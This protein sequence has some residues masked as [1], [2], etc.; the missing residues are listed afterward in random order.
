MISIVRLNGEPI[1][2]DLALSDLTTIDALE[3]HVAQVVFLK[4]YQCDEIV[5]FKGLRK[6]SPPE[7]VEE[8]GLRDGD[9][10]HAIICE[11]SPHASTHGAFTFVK[12]NGSVVTWGDADFDGDSERVKGA[13]TSGVQHIYSTQNAFAAVKADG[14]VVTWGDAFNG[15]DLS[16]IHI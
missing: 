10:L 2:E 9:F 8:I 5:F 6:L 12:A 4:G 3:G 14:S 1:L 16:L 15:G 7:S 11:T 13:L